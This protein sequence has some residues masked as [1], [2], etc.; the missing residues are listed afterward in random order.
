MEISYNDLKIQPLIYQDDIARIADSVVNAQKG[1]D[2]I[3]NI[4]ESKLL[5]L[6]TDKSKYVIIASA[7][8]RSKFRRELEVTPLSLYGLPLKESKAEKYL[9]DLIH[10]EG[11]GA[12]AAATVGERAGK[13]VTHIIEARAIIED[14]RSNSVGALHAGL[15]IW[16]LAH[17]PAL[18]HNCESW[19]ELE[20]STIDKLERL[21]NMM[22]RVLLSVPKSCPTAALCWEF[23]AV[24][25]KYRIIEKKLIFL[26][27]IVT[28][29]EGNLARQMLMIQSKAKFPGLVTEGMKMIKD[30]KLPNPLE[31]KIENKTWKKMVKEAVLKANEGELREEIL[32]LKKLAKGE[33][34]KEKF[35]V[36]EYI[37]KLNLS[38]GRTKF[39]IRAKMVQCVKFNYRRDKSFAN[40]LWK[41]NFCRKMDSQAHILICGKYQSL[42]EGKNLKSDS[43]LAKYVQQVI[44]SRI[45]EEN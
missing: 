28:K 1:N 26:N 41:C 37:Q 16:N 8:E 44:K 6:N 42:R 10:S 5:D 32:K 36:K 27:D 2:T 29:S 21:Q 17:I 24:K 19:S 45:E 20:D 4:M 34:S 9:G 40:D 15:D 23:G 25:M 30:L 39:Q 13:A 12:S 7:K 33:M 3:E 38:E 43:D 18:I 35:G 31:S 22:F 14:C 11:N